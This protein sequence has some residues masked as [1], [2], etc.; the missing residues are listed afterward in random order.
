MKQELYGCVRSCG[1]EGFSSNGAFPMNRCDATV[2]SRQPLQVRLPTVSGQG[3]EFRMRVGKERLSSSWQPS[4]AVG[5]GV[6]R[7]RNRAVHLL[8]ASAFLI[9]LRLGALSNPSRPSENSEEPQISEFFCPWKA[10]EEGQG[11]TV[12]SP[13]GPNRRRFVEGIALRYVEVNQRPSGA[14]A[15]PTRRGAG[16]CGVRRRRSVSPM[17]WGIA[18]DTP[19]TLTPQD[20]VPVVPALLQRPSSLHTQVQIIFF[21]PTLEMGSLSLSLRRCRDRTGPEHGVLVCQLPLSMINF[22]G[23]FLEPANL[24]LREPG[25]PEIEDLTARRSIRIR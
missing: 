3:Q 23:R 10:V 17:H 14:P 21:R 19:P 22:H 4:T 20:P 1:T 8:I 5:L 18:F 25:V 6:R 11:T 15:A 12:G 2:P 9:R 24:R 13:R 7:H 16:G